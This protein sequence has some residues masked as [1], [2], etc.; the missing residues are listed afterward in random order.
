MLDEI[1]SVIASHFGRTADSIDPNATFA[2]LGGD[3]LDLVEITMDVEDKL[4]LT[5]RDERLVAETG[6]ASANGICE[7]LTVAGFARVASTAPESKQS[8]VDSKPHSSGELYESQIGPYG[9]LSV[10]PN[11]NEFELVFIPDFADVQRFRAEE[12]GRDLTDSEIEELRA[13]SVVIALPA[14]VAAKMSR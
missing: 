12:M 10:L 2:E 8:S 3:D 13:K 1:K 14:D 7:R 4:K 9:E 11:P 5:I 6:S